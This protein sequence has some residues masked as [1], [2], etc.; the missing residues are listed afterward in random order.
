MNL[1]KNIAEIKNKYKNEILETLNSLDEDIAG[2][3]SNIDFV[4]DE[5]T[6]YA[7]IKPDIIHDLVT[8][9]RNKVV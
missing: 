9:L 8:Q 2:S 4:E 6:T 7:G 5:N 3:N 1:Y